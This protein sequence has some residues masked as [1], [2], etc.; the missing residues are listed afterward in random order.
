MHLFKN[1]TTT[2]VLLCLA[3]ILVAGIS[4]VAEGW[5]LGNRPVSVKE[6]RTLDG[7]FTDLA[8]RVPAFGGMFLEGQNLKVYLTDHNQKAAAEQ[9]IAAVFGRERIP[10]GGVQALKGDYGFHQLQGWFTRIGALFNIPG[11]VYT[12]IDERVNRLEIGRAHV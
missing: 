11:V 4:S 1:T 5:A 12:D 8:T 3:I 10:T 2:T 7:L 6:Q 9:A